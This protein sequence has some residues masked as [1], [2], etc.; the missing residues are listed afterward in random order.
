MIA[1][2]TASSHENASVPIQIGLPEVRKHL[3]VL[4]GR[5]AVNPKRIIAAVAKFY[6]VK[7]IALAGPSR[8]RQ[9]V[10]ARAV[11][12]YLCR[13][14]GNISLE[15][16]GKHFGGRDHTTALYSCRSIERRLKH[17]YELRGAIESLRQSLNER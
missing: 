16:L 6:G 9:V 5:R 1:R 7:S 3:T 2:A 13:S 14:T 17:D 12:M 8:R 4:R 10:L 15:A 11:A